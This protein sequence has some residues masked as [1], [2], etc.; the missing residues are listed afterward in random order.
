MENSVSENSLEVILTNVSMSTANTTV[1]SSV[2]AHSLDEKDQR[3]LKFIQDNWPKKIPGKLNPKYSASQWY[4]TGHK[5]EIRQFSYETTH[6][7]DSKWEVFSKRV[8]HAQKICQSDTKVYSYMKKS[9]KKRL[10]NFLT[11]RSGAQIL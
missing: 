8:L 1:N 7:N 6:K 4:S 3:L 9:T 11:D 5:P 10:I 2:V